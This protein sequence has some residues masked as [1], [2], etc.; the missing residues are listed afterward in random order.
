MTF[1]AKTYPVHRNE[2]RYV[3]G[4]DRPGN[5]KDYSGLC[6][7]TIDDCGIG[8][9]FDCWHCRLD[10]WKFVLEPCDCPW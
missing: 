6:A 5:L 7:G 10:S 1:V 4:A 9:L 8:L 2:A 3:R